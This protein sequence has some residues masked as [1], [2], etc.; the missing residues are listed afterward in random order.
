[1]LAIFL[2]IWYSTRNEKHYLKLIYLISFSFPLVFLGFVIRS[3]IQDPFLQVQCYF[4]EL[5]GNDGK[6]ILLDTQLILICLTLICY[7]L[8]FLKL[9]YDQM[10][11]QICLLRKSLYKTLAII[12]AIQIFGYFFSC[13]SYKIVGQIVL[14]EIQSHII[15][16]F[17]NCLS[18]LSS[19]IEV[20]VLFVVST[21]HNLALKDEFK[22]LFKLFS[23]ETK[24]NVVA[25]KNNEDIEIIERNQQNK[26]LN[27]TKEKIEKN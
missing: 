2:P 19:T 17:I 7:I 15:H 8:M 20:P 25:I 16:G 3:I 6:D 10:K 11:G 4:H 9:L 23:K 13:I 14:T 24:T 1:M 26:F 12:M 18:S 27:I 22:W 5:V 21:E